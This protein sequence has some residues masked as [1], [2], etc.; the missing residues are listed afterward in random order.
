MA[1]KQLFNATP[2]K[3][4]R[5]TDV[6]NDAG[7]KAYAFTPEHGLAQLASTGCLSQTFYVKAENQ[8]Q[9]VLEMSGKCSSE[10]VAK[11]A[12]YARQ[13]GFM[14]DM[15]AL[16]C[17][18]LAGRCKDSADEVRQDAKKWLELAFPRA[19]DNDKMLR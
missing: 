11:C 7:G 18:I 9:R 19:I 17:A 15:P 8:L 16:L 14:K 6:K 3:L 12:V 10:F 4:A 2:G 5:K 13:T 1:N